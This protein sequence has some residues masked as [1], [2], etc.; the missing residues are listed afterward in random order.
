MAV[1]PYIFDGGLLTAAAEVQGTTVPNLTKRLIR[2]AVL[3]NSTGAPVPATVYLVPAGGVPGTD[4]MVIS[5]LPIPDGPPAYPCPELINL[6]LNAGGTLQAFG[7][8]LT[9]HYTATDFL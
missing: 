8:G 7:D 4:N 5:A 9:F 2:A 6:G 3:C 1:S